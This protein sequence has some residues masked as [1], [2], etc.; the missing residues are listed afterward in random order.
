MKDKILIIEDE[1]DIAKLIK[2]HLSELDLH[3]DICTQGEQALQQALTQDYQLIL[4]DVMLPGISGLDICRQVRQEK[5]L[6]S[7]IMLTSKTSEIDRIL[8]LELGADDYMTK[9]FSIREL[10]AR[11][12]S[13]LRRVHA[14]RAKNSA[15]DN[16]QVNTANKSQE[17]TQVEQMPTSIGQLQ[18]DHRYH[19]V[20]Y[21]NKTINLTATE[22]ELID[23]FCKHP[24]QVFSRAQLLDG[25]WGYHHNGYEHTVN[26]HINRLR[27]KLEENCT[28]PKIIQT[29]WGVGYKLNSAGVM[30]VATS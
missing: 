17:Q 14:L 9:P 12:R 1:I 13:Q 27:S 18:V 24:D 3:C 29:V 28:E 11:V 22:F 16:E 6:Q 10:Q 7:I 30:P 2:V 19:Q 5:P 21:K 20:T 26:S 8:G 25:V 15:S 4:L 23:F